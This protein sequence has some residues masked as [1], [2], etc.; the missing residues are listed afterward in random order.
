MTIIDNLTTVAAPWFPIAKWGALALAII[1]PVA[2][3]HHDH[4]AMLDA[5]V[6]T[7]TAIK[8]RDIAEHDRDGAIA[9]NARFPAII[10][11]ANQALASLKAACEAASKEPQAAAEAVRAVPVKVSKDHGPVVMNAWFDAGFEREP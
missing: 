5:Q 8:D 3:W 9:A 2:G 10:A 6:A 11:S 1:I 7:A 4:K